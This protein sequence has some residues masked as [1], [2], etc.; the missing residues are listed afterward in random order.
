MTISSKVTRSGR[1]MVTLTGFD[2]QWGATM[3]GARVGKVS[4]PAIQPER[5]G[6]YWYT[7]KSIAGHTFADFAPD[8][9]TL[10]CAALD[11]KVLG[12]IVYNSGRVGVNQ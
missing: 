4:L 5:C 8:F 3:D 7:D 2:S 12:A 10:V 11:G 1:V 9:L 6:G